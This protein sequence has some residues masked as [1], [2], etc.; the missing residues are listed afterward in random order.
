ME[1]RSWG[2]YFSSQDIV[3]VTVGYRLGA[4]GFLALAEL[5]DEN[6]SYP[7]TGNYGLLDQRA[8]MQWVAQNIANFGGD[9]NRITIAGESAGASSVCYHLVMPKSHG[10][11]AQAILESSACFTEIVSLAQAEQTG[12]VG[13]RPLLL[14]T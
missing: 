6:A 5:L 1:L 2:N 9:P 3:V 12:L 8:A 10:L 11:F 14:T 7:T 4:I 13:S